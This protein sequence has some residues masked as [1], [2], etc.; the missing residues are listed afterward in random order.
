MRENLHPMESDKRRGIRA[1]NQRGIEIRMDSIVPSYGVPCTYVQSVFEDV[2]GAL[3]LPDPSSKFNPS[4]YL[5]AAGSSRIVD[6][7]MIIS[8]LRV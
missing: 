3:L 2:C 5:L 1:A 6:S 8:I 4:P 7:H